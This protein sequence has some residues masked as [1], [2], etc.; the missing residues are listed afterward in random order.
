MSIEAMK[1]ALEALESW[2]KGFPENMNDLD[3]QAI[4]ALRQAIEQAEQAHSCVACDDNPKGNNNPCAV[5]GLAQPEQE[6]FGWLYSLIV[7]GTV[8]NEKFTGVNWDTKYEPFGRHGVDHGGKVTK[9]PLYTTPPQHKP[10]TEKRIEELYSFW[11][12]DCQDIVGFARAV[13]RTVKGE[14]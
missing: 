3:D 2:H 8:V 11:V 12:V 5:C 10:L 7:E 13:E 14:V 1:Q 9:T 4:T 6:P